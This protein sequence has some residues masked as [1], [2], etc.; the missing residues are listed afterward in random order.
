MS[1]WKSRRSFE[2]DTLVRAPLE[3]VR[4]LFADPQR[5]VRLHPL[6]QDLVEEAENPGFFQIRE[7]VRFAGIPIDNRYRA[8]IARH[9][10]GVD[11]EAWSA[12]AIHVDNRLRWFA[13]GS[14]TRLRETC[15]I[16]APAP[17][18]GYVTRTARRAH[19]QQLERV[20]ATLD[21]ATQA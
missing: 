13:E 5:W 18:A 4:A 12:P 6:I 2:I 7:L 15:S 16:E 11:T 8:R 20:R 14:S 21:G 3:R 19:E 10:A 9:D 17:L 1:L